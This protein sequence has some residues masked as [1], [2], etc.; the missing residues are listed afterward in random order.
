MELLTNKNVPKFDVV[1]MNPPYGHTGNDKLHINITNDIK[2]FSN[3][4]ISLFPITFV[5]KVNNN[6]LFDI[7]K[8]FSKTLVFVKEISSTEFEKTWMPNIGIYVIKN[9]DSENINI[10]LLT[11]HFV[12]NSLNDIQIFNEYEFEFLNILLRNGTEDLIGDFCRLNSWKQPNQNKQTIL[13]KLVPNLCKKYKHQIE[14]K[15]CVITNTYIPIGKGIAFTKNLGK[16]FTKYEDI[17][18]FFI[19]HPYSRGTNLFLF[20]S[21]Q[22]AENFVI[23]I[24]NPIL[25]FT[26]YRLQD[27]QNLTKRIFKY[28]PNIDWSN[29]KVKTDEGLLE[30]C[31][32][33]IDKC[34]EYADYCKKYIEKVDNGTIDK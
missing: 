7:K 34:K 17:V 18:E 24:Q 22:A 14:N 28:V 33:P 1:I 21:V 15:I 30:V 6:K 8:E 11:K 2:K 19:E 25:R 13:K 5:T 31:G 9:T 29:D 26:I 20:N 4:T 32:C 10:E 27:D 23:A 3:M 12:V 16:I